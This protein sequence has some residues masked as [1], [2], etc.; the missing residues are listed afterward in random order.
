MYKFIPYSTIEKFLD[1]IKKNNVSIV[2]RSRNQ[3]LDKYKTYGENLPI[4]WKIKRENFIKRHLVQY[5]ANPT[6]RR[7]LALITWAYMP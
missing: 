4:T 2:A 5:N 6:Y 3:F 1:E 7:K